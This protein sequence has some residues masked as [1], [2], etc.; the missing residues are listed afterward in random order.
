MLPWQNTAAHDEREAFIAAWQEG[1]RQSR[2]QTAVGRAA[3]WA[4]R[5]GRFAGRPTAMRNMT[6]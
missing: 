2:V 5:G 6:L 1:R 4:P 3:H